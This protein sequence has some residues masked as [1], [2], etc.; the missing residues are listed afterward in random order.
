L[1]TKPEVKKLLLATKTDLE[2]KVDR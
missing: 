1:S 2:G